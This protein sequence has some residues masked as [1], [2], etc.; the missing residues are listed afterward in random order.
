MV[1]EL[2]LH[3]LATLI[4]FRYNHDT[5]ELINVVQR[6]NDDTCTEE[7]FDILVATKNY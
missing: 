3:M 6:K 7:Q 5:A 2:W 1:Y 4:D